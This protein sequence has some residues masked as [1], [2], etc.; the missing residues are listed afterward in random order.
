MLHPLANSG[1]VKE[2]WT[3]SQPLKR[4]SSGLRWA[5]ELPPWKFDEWTPKQRFSW[6]KEFRF[7]IYDFL[8]FFGSFLGGCAALG[9]CE[10]P[11]A[12]SRKWCI[13][14][15]SYLATIPHGFHVDGVEQNCALAWSN[16][17]FDPFCYSWKP[18]TRQTRNI[19]SAEL[20]WLWGNVEQMWNIRPSSTKDLYT[21]HHGFR[22]H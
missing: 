18:L 11:V 2:Q 8:V 4:I 13:Q 19:K 20:I 12:C 16:L 3:A 22:C 14:T 15:P 1:W 9:L 10:I 6:V 7:R 17:N 5:K 21:I